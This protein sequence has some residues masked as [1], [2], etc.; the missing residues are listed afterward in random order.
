MTDADILPITDADHIFH[1]KL[2]KIVYHQDGVAPDECAVSI[3]HLLSSSAGSGEKMTAEEIKGKARR[4]EAL[5]A[6]TRLEDGPFAFQISGRKRKLDED[7]TKSWG[8]GTA[9]DT[10]LFKDLR[11]WA[12][13]HC[14]HKA[15]VREM[16]KNHL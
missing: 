1:N 8:D 6:I 9:D 2:L 10:L 15:T 13:G 3:E 12:R 4:I 7:T 5:Q 14:G 16:I 11:Q